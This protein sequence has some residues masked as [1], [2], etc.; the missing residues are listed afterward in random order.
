MIYTNSQK[1]PT[2]S[3]SMPCHAQTAYIQTLIKLPYDHDRPELNKLYVHMYWKIWAMFRICVYVTLNSVRREI[4]STLTIVSY[5]KVRG[6][7]KAQRWLRSV[8]VRF[9]STNITQPDTISQDIIYVLHIQCN[10]CCM[11]TM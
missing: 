11:Y 6:R 2:N 9:F 10:S 1:L 3:R 4:V 8:C 5:D 7:N